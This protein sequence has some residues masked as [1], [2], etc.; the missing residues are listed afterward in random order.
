MRSA[1]EELVG[2]AQ[3]KPTHAKG[4]RSRLDTGQHPR[5]FQ[6]GFNFSLGVFSFLFPSN[7]TYLINPNSSGRSRPVLIRHKSTANWR[8]T[9]TMAFL[10][11]APVASAPLRSVAFHLRIGL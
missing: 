3:S 1:E 6:S 5:T 10:R 7:F 11:A 8:A 4:I 2:A 9:A